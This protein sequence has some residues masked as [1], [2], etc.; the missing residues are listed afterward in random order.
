MNVLFLGLGSIGQRH[1][2]I[3]K[4]NF[5]NSF[6]Y[7]AVRKIGKNIYIKDGIAKKVNSLSVFYGFTEFDN[8]D[9]AFSKV[10]FD[11]VFVTNPSSDHYWGVIKAI[12]NGCAVFVEKPICTSINEANEIYDSYQNESFIYTGY[13]THFDPL[14]IYVK[15][16]IKNKSF[17]PATSF[18]SEW[19]TYLPY[20][21]KYEDYKTSYASRSNLG[22][23]VL[24]GLSH[25]LDILIDLFGLPDI[26]KSIEVNNRSLNIDADDTFIMLCSYSNRSEEFG[27]TITLSYSQIKETRQLYLNYENGFI[28]CDFVNRFCSFIMNNMSEPIIFRDNSTTRN[29]IFT[30]QMKQFIKSVQEKN[31]EF[32]NFLKSIDV[33]KFIEMIKGG[34]IN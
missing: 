7:F 8:V 12:K 30:I 21:H 23:G 6:N 17:G 18:R 16:L 29:D 31:F 34:K 14:Y 4:D 28:M 26:V 11:I 20:H 15:N 25:E 1:L 19:C 32:D 24:L 27:G 33:L 22:G 3:L 2:Q 10:S 9:E 13:Q 5:G